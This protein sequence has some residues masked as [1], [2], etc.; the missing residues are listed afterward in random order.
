MGLVVPKILETALMN[1]SLS[2]EINKKLRIWSVAGSASIV[3]ICVWGYSI[4]WES[5]V[6][7]FLWFVPI[8]IGA[9]S[10][11]GFFR[12]DLLKGRRPDL[13]LFCYFSSILVL[14]IGI[15]NFSDDLGSY[16]LVYLLAVL[17]LCILSWILSGRRNG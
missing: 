1:Y 7:Y 16:L 10:L 3:T 8:T 12:A 5:V 6:G 4:Y 15:F 11:F 13:L 17:T 9:L 14:I 2:R